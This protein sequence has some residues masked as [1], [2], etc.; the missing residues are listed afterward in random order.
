MSL[1]LCNSVH[2]NKTCSS[3]GEIC[4]SSSKRLKL[5][6]LP[7]WFCGGLKYPAFPFPFPRPF[8]LKRSVCQGGANIENV[9]ERSL[10]WLE[11]FSFSVGTL[12]PPKSD[13]RRPDNPPRVGQGGNIGKSRHSSRQV[14]GMSWDSRLYRLLRLDSMNVQFK[15]SGLAVIYL[16]SRKFSFRAFIVRCTCWYIH[17]YSILFSIWHITYFTAAKSTLKGKV[18]SSRCNCMQSMSSC[19]RNVYLG[20]L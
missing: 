16:C 4:F 7:G 18:N 10:D 15:S 5:A 12:E 14:S 11:W 6:Q 1:L 17:I 2:Q 19:V 3:R 20:I 13:A 9:V 8:R